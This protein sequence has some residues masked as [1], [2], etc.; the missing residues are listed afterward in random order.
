ML[1]V[2]NPPNPYLSEVREFLGPPPPARLEV[3][4]EQARTV[5]TANDSPDVPFRFSV[6]P[7]RG[8][9]HACA[10][11]YARRTHEY[12]GLGA[13]TDFETAITVKINAPELL[14]EAFS[15]RGWTREP[16]SFSGVTDPYQ[17]LEAVYRLTRSCLEVASRFANPIAVITKSY[18]IVR[19]VQRRAGVHVWFSIPFADAAVV[20]KLEPHVPAPS[21]Q[22]DAMQKLAQAGVSVG[23]MIAPV[24]PGL[25]DRDIPA[26]LKQAADAGAAL[27]NYSPVRLP[28]SVRDVFL[29]RL[30]AE[31][32]D[33]AKRVET[34]ILELR[35][36][37]WND[38]RFGY[39][40]RAAGV[41]WDSVR[42]LFNT[43]AA[44]HG[45]RDIDRSESTGCPPA[46]PPTPTAPRQLS[47]F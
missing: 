24:I 43:M 44:R 18:L 35:G 17:P 5:L 23:L 40:M 47:L 13:G 11:C 34:R 37:K 14:A 7:Y 4:E 9:Q 2:A 3:Y 28:G 27:A 22:F 1:R 19:D 16:V 31:L 38:P 39:R 45:F 41:Y 32:P 10:Y 15:R 12:L 29:A 25:N 33:A 21:R 30:R 42:R 26:L 8:C 6:N 46:A 20:R 36:G